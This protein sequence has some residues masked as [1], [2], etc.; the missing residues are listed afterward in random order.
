MIM[1]YECP[2]CG[3]SK[4]VRKPKEQDATEFADA[5]PEK[6]DCS[7]GGTCYPIIMNAREYV[8]EKVKNGTYNKDGD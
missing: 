5:L 2:S 1:T 4:T 7:C 6:L 3:A 8:F